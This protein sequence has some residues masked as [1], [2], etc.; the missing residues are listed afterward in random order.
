MKHNI[1]V[2]KSFFWLP[3][4]VLIITIFFYPVYQF[5]INHF[6]EPESIIKIID[7]G[8]VSGID[9]YC[10]GVYLGQTPIEITKKEFENK[11]PKWD[12]PPRQPRLKLFRSLV[13]TPIAIPDYPG[14]LMSYSPR[15]LMPDDQRDDIMHFLYDGN[16][17]QFLNNF[18]YWFNFKK[19]RC[20]GVTGIR[21][22]SM[23]SFGFEK[24]MTYEYYPQ[25]EFLSQQEHLETLLFA[26]RHSEY[27]PDKAWVEHV[28]RYSGLL[29]KELVWQSNKDERLK[30]AADAIV[31]A[32]FNIQ[33]GMNQA[34]CIRVVDDIMARSEKSG[35]FLIPS[36]ES[37]AME[38]VA[39]Q[40][41][42]YIC[43]QYKEFF[44]S[45][46]PSSRRG[47]YMTD[48]KLLNFYRLEG[49]LA[50]KLP[51]EYAILKYHPPQIYNYLVYNFSQLEEQNL[52]RLIG[53]YQHNKSAS[54][55][56]QYFEKKLNEERFNRNFSFNLFRQL[57]NPKLTDWMRN[58][59][60]MHS[61]NSRVSELKVFFESRINDPNY[62]KT[63]LTN[64]IGRSNMNENDK[65]QLLSKIKVPKSY[66]NARH[67]LMNNPTG[68]EYLINLLSK[69]P[70]PHFEP[71]LLETLDKQ[72][73]TLEIKRI[74]SSLF[75]ALIKCDTAKTREAILDKWNENILGI[76]KTIIHELSQL[77]WGDLILTHW[78]QMLTTTQES[79][80]RV[81]AVEALAR[82][83]TPQSW[84][85][86]YEWSG[87]EDKAIREAA[88]NE[89]NDYKERKNQA[90]ALIKGEIQ[91][92]DL[93]PPAVPY[94]WNE[95]DYVKESTGG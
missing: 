91:P 67:I 50:R 77:E 60:E 57:Y 7:N 12:A 87:D 22:E 21:I 55:V 27:K 79:K 58:T 40:V 66:S 14:L 47:V 15:N 88:L 76:N 64:D 89:I 11:V 54:L 70:N 59:I 78:T 37:Y 83:D 80:S 92:D 10:N 49:K 81:M 74:S 33:E 86:I 38:M 39:P 51:L 4:A 3:F 41:L 93:L 84:K 45:K 90:Q 6:S 72:Y 71:F 44:R 5:Y 36:L 34:E 2:R 85:V 43:E 82:T 30:D 48:D 52:L 62:S 1:I 63:D 53:N 8:Y 61:P 9:V 26:L 95:K 75:G 20:A 17:E 29:F 56:K 73:R 35:S 46:Q 94:V 19:Y 23:S 25:V 13:E 68:E 32:E 31:R 28:R 24:R 69:N 18:S 65:I 16:H 42:E